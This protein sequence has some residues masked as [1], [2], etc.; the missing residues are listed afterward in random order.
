MEV[1]IPDCQYPGHGLH[2][3]L[4]NTSLVLALVSSLY[5]N[6]TLKTQHFGLDAPMAGVGLVGCDE[7][8]R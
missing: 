7:L 8:G 6:F 5:P 1:N 2:H 3:R 4:P